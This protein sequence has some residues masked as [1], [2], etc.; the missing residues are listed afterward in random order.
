MQ[1][2]TITEEYKSYKELKEGEFFQFSGSNFIQ[3]FRAGFT[4]KI[5]TEISVHVLKCVVG[6][7]IVAK[8]G[9][10]EDLK[11]GDWFQFRGDNILRKKGTSNLEGY[12]RLG[13]KHVFRLS[14]ICSHEL[15]QIKSYH[16][17]RWEVAE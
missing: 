16:V 15:A 17:K 9:N 7:V 14:V 3:Q 2:E 10:Y 8:E 5:G 4:P 12:E 11:N 1:R 6:G 13:K